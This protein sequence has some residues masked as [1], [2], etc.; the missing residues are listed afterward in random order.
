MIWSGRSCF[1]ACLNF[2]P[3]LIASFAEEVAD[4]VALFVQFLQRRLH[5]LLAELAHLDALDDLVAAAAGGHRVAVDHALRDAVASV[6]R[7]THRDP[8]AIARAGDPVA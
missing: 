4:A 2:A 8:V 3:A 1:S 7:H 5:A 6:G